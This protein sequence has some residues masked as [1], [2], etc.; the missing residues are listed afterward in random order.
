MILGNNK[1]DQDKPEKVQASI[2]DMNR[3][4][5][6]EDTTCDITNL[7]CMDEQEYT[8]E[9]LHIIKQNMENEDTTCEI[10]DMNCED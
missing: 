5:E 2:S 1:K 8:Q 6:D 10:T 3:V 9:E 4:S 7:N